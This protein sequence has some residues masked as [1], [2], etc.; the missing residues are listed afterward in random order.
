MGRT[1]HARSLA[2]LATMCIAV[3]CLSKTAIGGPAF[4][5]GNAFHTS[6]E[7]LVV[8]TTRSDEFTPESDT[9]NSPFKIEDLTASGANSEIFA[10]DRNE[11]VNV[12]LDRMF[13]D[14]RGVSGDFDVRSDQTQVELLGGRQDNPQQLGVRAILRSL[15]DPLEQQGGFGERVGSGTISSSGLLDDIVTAALGDDDFDVFTTAFSPEIETTGLVNF[16]LDAIGNFALLVSESFGGINV[17]DPETGD[18][19]EVY[20][21]RSE[22]PTYTNGA[23]QQN[24]GSQGSASNGRSTSRVSQLVVRLKRNAVSILTDPLFIAV[25][26]GSMI[27]WVLLRLRGRSQA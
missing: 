14:I 19:I 9:A 15:V 18:S 16:T 3:G 12:E 20:E 24:G 5:S 22:N 10:I 21:S 17:V 25:L 4:K 23:G 6:V 7:P 2:I 27:F 8:L 13:A 26:M 11:R 1:T